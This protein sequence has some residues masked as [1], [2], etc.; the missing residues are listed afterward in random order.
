LQAVLYQ[1][2]WLSLDV[3]AMEEEWEEEGDLGF[4]IDVRGT[5]P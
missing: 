4:L 5:G 3:A 2:S 1:L